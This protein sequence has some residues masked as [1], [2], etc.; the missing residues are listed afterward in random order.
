MEARLEAQARL[1]IPDIYRSPITRR[2]AER[3][4]NMPEPTRLNPKE[5]VDSLRAAADRSE[6]IYGPRYAKMAFNAATKMLI[7][8]GNEDRDSAIAGVLSKM[9]QG[10]PVTQRELGRINTLDEISAMDRVF[11]DQF[12]PGFVT[13]E[14]ARPFI[15]PEFARETMPA[16][17]QYA[18]REAAKRPMPAQIEWVRQDPK[19][20]QPIFDMEFGRGA[21]ARFANEPADTTKEPAR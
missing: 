17:Q 5:F 18:A 4:L 16:I 12:V 2:E 20:R 7:K 1:G 10:E 11:S 9:V 13:E 14:T 19:T 8:S 15:S 3:L 6:Q 21:W